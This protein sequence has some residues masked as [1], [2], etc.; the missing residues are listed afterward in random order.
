MTSTTTPAGPA[1]VP[2]PDAPRPDAPRPRFLVGMAS[3]LVSGLLSI[4]WLWISLTVLVT[5]IASLPAV[6]TGLLLLVPW[7]LV[8]RAAA[9]FE[10]RRARAV[11]GVDVV[12]PSRRVA[13]GTGLGAALQNL[14]LDVI[15]WQFWRSV[16]H[17]HITMIVGFFPSLVLYVGLWGAWTAAELAIMAPDAQLGSWR[18]GALVLALGAVLCLA[19]ALGSLAAGVLA[20]R[21]LARVMLPSSDDGLRQEV[22]ELSVRRQGAVDAAEQERLRIERDLHDGVQPRLVA[23]AMTLGMARSRIE[24]DPAGAAELV[25]EAHDEAKAVITDLRQLAR[26]IHPAVLADRGLDPALSALA[27]RSPVPVGLTVA[28]PG[29]LG[30]EQEAVAYFVVSEAL[31]NVAKHAS[32][33]HVR[34]DVT[35]AGPADRPG[36][37]GSSPRL[38]GSPAPTA[39]RVRI[40][41]DGRGGA[42]VRRDGVSTGLAGLTDRVRA[43]GGHLVVSSPAG[44]PTILDATIPASA[45]STP[46]REPAGAPDPAPD[47][48][49]KETHR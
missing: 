27:A 20:E 8:M 28:V 22:Q 29:R 44:G 41:D 38:P 43:T 21:G 35:L 7:V 47:D 10:R 16:L 24:K 13:R 31:T 18:P 19:I 45:P 39:L 3:V 40:E 25:D 6:L 15:S 5:G 42:H 32:A 46:A 26:G 33:S 34:V 30:R 12:V 23:L 4:T 14:G 36:A 9:A 1:P 2:R 48:S 37:A 49:A 11:H 17:H